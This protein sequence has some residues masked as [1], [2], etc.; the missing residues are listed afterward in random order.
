MTWNIYLSGEIHDLNEGEHNIKVLFKSTY[1]IEYEPI[2]WKFSL[3]H[4]NK[5]QFMSEY[6]K[7]AGKIKYNQ[8][9]QIFFL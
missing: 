5:K 9:N 8:F 3:S 1:G 4:P 6:I 7:Q 2:I